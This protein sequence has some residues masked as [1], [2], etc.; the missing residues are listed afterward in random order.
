M[1]G[2]GVL[3]TE[4]TVQ[5]AAVSVR[6][7]GL[8]VTYRKRTVLDV[9]AIEIPAGMTYAVVG[10]SGAGKSTLLRVL[11]L[12]E[13][14]TEGRVFIAGN[15]ASGRSLALRR[16]I[17]AVFQKPY[18]LRGTVAANV[19]YGLRLRGIGRREREERAAEALAGVGLAGWEG[20]SALTLSGGEAQRV[21]LARAL[22]LRPS[23]LLLDE[24]LSYLD[25]LLKREL[26]AEFARILASERVTALY[27]THDQ[28]EASVVADR[29][30]VMRDGTIVSEGTSDEVLG[31]PTDEWVASF[32]GMQPP[33]RGTVEACADGL[34]TIDV[35][36]TRVS[37]ARPLD[38][39]S[40]VVAAVRPEDV[41]LYEAGAELPVGSAR[42]HLSAEVTDMRPQGGTIFLVLRA[43]GATF[44]ATVSRA[45]AEELALAVGLPVTAVFKATAVRA[46]QAD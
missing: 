2:D 9:P 45:S 3:E 35:G 41:T 20:R 30:A 16:T 44:A 25:P 19:A 31:L 40:H 13:S 12:L 33:L 24:P 43:G 18:L 23:L 21:A 37:V 17:A 1:R 38:V 36:G 6:G 7:E 22:V 4:D 11:G 29:M 10:A 32:V 46:R 42:N 8:R 26:T 27:V 28:D 5:A 39:G 15:E 14:P 34:S